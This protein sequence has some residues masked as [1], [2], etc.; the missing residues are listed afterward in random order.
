MAP[1]RLSK[2]LVEQAVQALIAHNGTRQAAATAL[3]LNRDTFRNRLFRAKQYGIPI[4]EFPEH[5]QILDTSR[6]HIGSAEQVK[7]DRLT[8]EVEFL[9]CENASLREERLS[10]ELIRQLI[11]DCKTPPTPPSWRIEPSPKGNEGTPTVLCSDWHWGETIDRKQINYVN[12]FD[13]EI[14]ERRVKL[15]VSK[16]IDL[17]LKK[18]SN[19]KYDYLCMPLLGDLLSGTIH[20][21]LRETNWDPITLCL[22]QLR[23]VLIWAIDEFANAFKKVYLPCVTGNHGR[24]DRKP[25]Y[26]NAAY[27]NYEFVLYEMLRHHYQ[28]ERDIHFEIAD[29]PELLYT[30]GKTRYLAIHGD[31]WRGGSG[32]A[33]ALSPMMLGRARKKETA[34]ATNRPFDVIV[35]GHWHFYRTLG[36]IICNGSLKGF[37]EYALKEGYPFQVPIQAVWITHPV[38]TLTAYWPIYLET[39]GK[40]YR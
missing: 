18:M 16:T 5:G 26:K 6:V 8:K 32:I 23:D 37:D 34:L 40:T 20:E 35:H 17:L 13:R 9:K 24:L 10:V 36:D 7:I 33:G 27:D 11:H 39:P 22:F 2:E 31:S 19:P 12:A 38:H 25:R 29:G 15:L 14:A 4:P 21:E 3:G 28:S 1:P 30:L